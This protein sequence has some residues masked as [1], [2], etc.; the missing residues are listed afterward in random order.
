MPGRL[1]HLEGQI[2]DLD[3]VKLAASDNSLLGL[4][5]RTRVSERL[6]PS[7]LLGLAASSTTAGASEA[8]ALLRSAFG[9]NTVRAKDSVAVGGLL[10]TSRVHNDPLGFIADI[11]LSQAQR[12]RVCGRLGGSSTTASAGDKLSLAAARKHW[13]ARHFRRFALDAARADDQ[14]VMSTAAAIASSMRRHDSSA[15]AA[16]L[17]AAQTY[18]LASGR[19]TKLAQRANEVLAAAYTLAALDPSGLALGPLGWSTAP[20]VWRASAAPW[21][22]AILDETNGPAVGS[23]LDAVHARGLRFV[24][25]GVTPFAFRDS[26]PELTDARLRLQ[27][28]AGQLTKWFDRPMWFDGGAGQVQV[29]ITQ[30]EDRYMYA[31]VGVEGHGMLV[32]FDLVDGVPYGQDAPGVRAAL[33][34]A[35]GWYLDVSISLRTSA[36]GTSALRRAAVGTVKTGARYVP[37]PVFA[38]Q[39]GAKGVNQS[40][41][42][43]GVVAHVRTFKNGYKPSANARKNAPARLRAT[44]QSN[45]TFVRAY[46]K[47]HG[48]LALLKVHL[49]KH[50]ALADVLAGLQPRRQ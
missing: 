39:I 30:D 48:N 2:W 40:P 3:A 46:L 41:R 37:Q 7:A 35:I 12:G 20:P 25:P 29:L 14:A 4:L 43:H 45:Q 27:T 9:F 6:G 8:R 21:V 42:L 36:I 11:K 13:D 19:N 16:Q 31:W 1:I 50:S 47:G 18:P 34:L 49:S 17:T 23:L 44:M 24:Q 5:E 26:T 32:A 10:R 15:F 33:A 38:R 28:C 22:F